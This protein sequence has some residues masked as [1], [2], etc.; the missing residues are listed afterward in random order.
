MSIWEATVHLILRS[1]E[2]AD[3]KA[4]QHAIAEINDMQQCITDMDRLPQRGAQMNQLRSSVCKAMRTIKVA[5]ESAG[6][7]VRMCDVLQRHRDKLGE[8][9]Q[10]VF[11]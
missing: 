4:N 11:S 3:Q 1:V 10:E 2:D 8:V 9:I 7:A 6:K 5:S